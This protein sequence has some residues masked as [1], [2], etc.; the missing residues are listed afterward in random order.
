MHNR[1]LY[2]IVIYL[3]SVNYLQSAEVVMTESDFLKIVGK[4]HPLVKQANLQIQKGQSTILKARGAFDPT[5]VADYEN[6]TFEDKSYYE[7]LSTGLKI[8]IWYGPELNFA[9][10]SSSGNYLNPENNLPDEGLVSAGIKMPLG[11]GLFFDNRR[12]TFRQ[13]EIFDKISAVEQIRYLA[14]LYYDAI[15]A[16]WNWSA[17]YMKLKLNEEILKIAQVRFEGIKQSFIQG[18]IPAIDT[19]ETYLQI[20]NFEMN[21]QSARYEYINSGLNLSNFLWNENLIPLEVS[22]NLIPFNESQPKVRAMDDVKLLTNNIDSLLNIH[23]ELEVYNLKLEN[24][25]V[26]RRL[27]AEYLKPKLDLKYD[28]L[29]N[30][31]DINT[32]ELYPEG[33]YKI[34]VDFKMPIFLRN[35][36][37]DVQLT[38]IKIAETEIQIQSKRLELKNKINSYLNE[39][40]ILSSNFELFTNALQNYRILFEAEQIKFNSG[41]SS[42]FLLNSRENSLL[43]A[44]IKQIDLFAKINSKYAAL[45]WSLGILGKEMN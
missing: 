40:E 31:V 4:N 44:G 15:D 7:I 11:Q 13:A 42:L 9:Y 23:P 34:G 27:K 8:P 26:E 43:N 29:N 10:Q 14:D 33:N 41:E 6:K 1:V 22:E 45:R 30:A 20:L 39:I 2:F 18:D 25:Q 21:L 3:L 17:A 5:L 36:R 24:L 28:Y 37:G 16:Y 38:D 35:E 32:N 19:L 12:A